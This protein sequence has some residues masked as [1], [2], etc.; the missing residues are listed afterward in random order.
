MKVHKTMTMAERKE[1]GY[2]GYLERAKCNRKIFVGYCKPLIGLSRRWEKVTCKR[3]LAKM[4]YQRPKEITEAL[5]LIKI[6]EKEAAK[7][8]EKVKN[9]RL[10]R[11]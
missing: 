8:Q 1:L 3:C 10:P 7:P 5:E 2:E 4:G 11:I 9:D 6:M